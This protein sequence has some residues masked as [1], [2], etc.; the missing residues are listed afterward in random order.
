MGNPLNPDL[1]NLFLSHVETELSEESWFPRVWIRYVDDVFA[2]IKAEHLTSILSHLNNTKWPTL[3]FTTESEKNGR[4]TF[5]DLLIE[6]RNDSLVLGV[7][8]RETSTKRYVTN[9]SDHCLQHKK[10]ALN[11][12]VYHLVNLPLIED[13]YE[14]EKNRIYEVASVNGY[15]KSMVNSFEK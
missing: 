12:M 13:L 8:H 15:Q 11:S 6:R 2:I 4:L 3:K 10:A 14:K 1:E 9:D 7:H 5:L